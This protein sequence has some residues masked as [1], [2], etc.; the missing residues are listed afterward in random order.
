MEA[1]FAPAWT[2]PL[3]TGKVSA[4]ALSTSTN[5]IANSQSH[6]LF[7]SQNTDAKATTF[8]IFDAILH[9]LH[10]FDKPVIIALNGPALGGGVGLLT[11]GDV[12]FAHFQ[13]YIAL[14]EVRRGLVPALISPWIVSWAGK[15]RGTE[16]MMRG[17]RI[18]SSQL[19]KLG[20][21]SDLYEADHKPAQ[22]PTTH[23]PE[24]VYKCCK[25]LIKGAPGALQQ[26]K[27]LVRQ[28][29]GESPSANKTQTD[30]VKKAFQRM[31]SSDEAS[32]GISSYMEKKEPDWGEYLKLKANL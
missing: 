24:P 1:T 23:L 3:L 9:R 18:N 12:R 16:W 7:H 30:I 5:V 32:Y 10:A 19:L 25:D 15:A 6:R 26:V 28:I 17:A 2:S 20:L 14:P 13:S 31:I 22:H 8:E 4:L 21:L 29:T 11:A 27:S